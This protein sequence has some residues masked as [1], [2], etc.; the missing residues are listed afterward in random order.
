MHESKKSD[1]AIRAM[2]LSNKAGS[3]AAAEMAEQRDRGERDSAKH[4]PHAD[5]DSRVPGAG[6][7]TSS[8]KGQEE[9]TVHCAAPPR[10]PGS[11]PVVVL[12]PQAER[13]TGSGR[14]DVG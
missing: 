5:A 13:G 9:G 12:R 6:A 14:G 3:H 2:N 8:S 7:R 4:A 10:Q 11:A 1:P